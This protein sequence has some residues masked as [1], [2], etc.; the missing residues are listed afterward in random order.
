MTRYDREHLA[1]RIVQHHTT[2]AN[3]KKIVTV[4]HFVDENVPRQTIYN[5]ILKY[6]TSDF[7]GDKPRS[8]RPR[9][10]S[11]GQRTRLKRLVNHHTGISLRKVARKFDVHRRTIQ[12]ELNRMEIQY[13]KKK[14]VPLCRKKQF[15]EV[16]MRAGR[17]YRTLTSIDFELI[18]NDEKV[19]TVIN[20]SVSTNRGFYTTDPD[21][22]PAEVKFKRTQKYSA[23]VMVW[24]ALSEKGISEPF[25]AKQHQSVNEEKYLEHCIKGH[26]MPFINRYH[27]PNKVLFWLDL[28]SSHFASSV[29]DF[30][31][32]QKIELVPKEKNPQN[33]PQARPV[34]TLW[35]I[36]EEKVYADGWEAKT[37]NQLKRRIQTKLKE[38]DMTSVQAMFSS[39]LQQL[40]KI[41][42]DGPCAACSF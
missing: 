42:T 23:K 31:D 32:E 22:S 38:V 20:E 30:F 17:L 33:G 18:M 2:I 27:D 7:V 14:W 29:I 6:D 25:F 8:G 10:I 37:I 5:I 28:A 3:R 12:R 11:S 4:N 13:C 9:K 39:I 15:E 16:P 24:I 35:Q 21:V 41:A 40:R 34:E 19:F 36:L 26:L 1:K